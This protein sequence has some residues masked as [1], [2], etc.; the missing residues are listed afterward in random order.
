[1]PKLANTPEEL[2][3]QEQYA[4]SVQGLLRLARALMGTASPSS[5]RQL[6]ARAREVIARIEESL[7]HLPED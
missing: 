4:E 2:K 7:I 3:G 5:A 1:M 6:V